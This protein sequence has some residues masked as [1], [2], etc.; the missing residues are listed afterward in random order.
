MKSE[1]RSILEPFEPSIEQIEIKPRYEYHFSDKIINQ[2]KDI[3]E[4]IQFSEH[5]KL[6]WQ[7]AAYLII[8]HHEDKVIKDRTG[9][10]QW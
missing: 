2:F 5:L 9:P 4:T 8:D 1:T 3:R 7:Y 6:T 10:T